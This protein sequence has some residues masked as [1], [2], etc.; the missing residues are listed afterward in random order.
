MTL[1]DW[2]ICVIKK[3]KNWMIVLVGIPSNSKTS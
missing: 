2:M 1:I 3:N